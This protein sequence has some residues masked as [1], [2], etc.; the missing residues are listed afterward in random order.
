MEDAFPP[1][2]AL[3]QSEPGDRNH[4][5]RTVLRCLYVP[6]SLQRKCYGVRE[7]VALNL[8]AGGLRAADSKDANLV[9]PARADRAGRWISQKTLG[10]G[11]Q[12][13][14]CHSGSCRSTHI[15][16]LVENALRRGQSPDN[17]RRCWGD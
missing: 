10:V 11:G 12:E 17:S 6:L 13:R 8:R 2:N 16:Q 3:A 4:L 5:R 7:L 15:P 14:N 1:H 9:G